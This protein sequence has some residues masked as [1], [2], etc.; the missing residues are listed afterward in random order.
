MVQRIVPLSSGVLSTKY[1]VLPVA[2][3]LAF[4]A[5]TL[6]IV[7]ADT[8]ILESGGQ[9]EGQWLNRDEQPATRYEIR[10]GAITLTLPLAQVREAI[11]QSPAEAEYAVR[12]PAVTDTADAQWVFAEWCRKNGLKAQREIHLRRAIE[13]D[14]NHQQARFALGYQYIKG[15]WITQGDS[16]R[17][18]GYELYRGKWR[19]PHE[20]EIL[21][22]R[23][24]NELAE[25]EWLSRL[26]KWRRELDDRDKSKLARDALAAINDPIAVGP[27]SDFLARER[28]RSVKALYADVLARINNRDA[29]RVLINQALGDPD[30]EVF[31]YCLDRLVQLQP[32]HVAD[33]FI[34]ALKNN[35]NVRVNRGAIALGRLRD[36]TAVSPLIDALTT[37][38]SRVI[39]NGAG[40]E[41]TTA[42]FANGNAFMKKG[43]AAELQVF[44]IQNQ[45]VLDALSKLTSVNFGFDQKAWRYWYAQEKVARET[46]KPLVDARKE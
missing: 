35:D 4:F 6:P 32:P 23:S 13:L 30:E 45:P 36:K 9:I 14:P 21:E 2:A 27:I 46:A 37:T 33:P 26:K 19:L 29:V 41:A 43:D 39:N 24:R 28:V 31:F 40:A 8:F 11:R 3:A 44:H 1:S 7:R 16:R 34:A 12:A 5:G 25:K 15:E 10:Q 22:S 42:G 17:Q 18:E 20:I 38:H